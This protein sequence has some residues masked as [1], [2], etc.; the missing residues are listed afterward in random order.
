M[1]SE[2]L[3]AHLYTYRARC[4]RVVDGDTVD[5]DIDLGLGIHNH[6]RVRLFGVDTPE[7]CGVKKDSEEFAAGLRVKEAVEKALFAR[8]MQNKFTVPR[9]IWVETHRD[10]TG[11]YG[12]YL[13]VIWFK[14]HGEVISLNEHLVKEGLAE[15]RKY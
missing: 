8:D 7:T 11:K 5:L 3:D 14:I 15:K 6:Q 1:T 4:S 12:C 10:K 9:N 2:I 13:A